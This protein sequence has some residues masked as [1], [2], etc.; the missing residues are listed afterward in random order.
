MLLDDIEIFTK[1]VE[2]KS[3]SIASHLL[4]VPKSTLSRRVS[5]MEEHL[6]LNAA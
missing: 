4:R 6:G 3:F 1:V 2:Y 5:Q